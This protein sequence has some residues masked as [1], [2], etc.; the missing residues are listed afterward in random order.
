MSKRVQVMKNAGRSI[1]MELMAYVGIAAAIGSIWWGAGLLET[2]GMRPGDGGV[3]RP[4]EERL[5]VAGITA[6]CGLA[7]GLGLL[8]YQS[9][10]VVGLVLEGDRF[11]VHTKVGFL[12]IIRT[13]KITDVAKS[14]YRHNAE[15]NFGSTGRD[16]PREYA[17]TVRI[18]GR[19]LPYILDLNAKFIDRH[20][21]FK[22]APD[23]VR[24]W[25]SDPSAYRG[26]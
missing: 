23:A 13:Y 26:S 2:Y 18:S 6:G 1:R 3:L 9:L 24:L 17:M 5:L 22:I 7:F 10:Y 19:W 21:L 11:D 14:S 8:I 12:N 15:V 25:N 20:A 4:F 16:L